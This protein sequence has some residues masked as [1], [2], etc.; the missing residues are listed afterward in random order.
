[1]GRRVMILGCGRLGATVAQS[2]IDK[3]DTVTILDRDADNFRRLKEQ[4][5]L[6]M[7]VADGTSNEELIRHGIKETDVFISLASQDTINALA[8][9]TALLTFGVASVVCRINDSARRHMYEAIGLKTVSPPEVMAQ[10]VLDA[11][12]N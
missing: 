10:L 1:M 11:M 4:P 5:T 12:E 2:L 9:Q 3:G 6:T 8:G 7:V